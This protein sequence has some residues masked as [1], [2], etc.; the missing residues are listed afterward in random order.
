[1]LS[2]TWLRYLVLLLWSAT[3]LASDTSHQRALQ[4]LEQLQ[5]SAG[6]VRGF[7]EQQFNPMLKQPVE[8]SGRVWIDADQTM[9][10]ELVQPRPEQRRLQGDALALSRP[11]SKAGQAPDFSRIHHRL[12]L[13]PDK[14]AH[15]ILLAAGALLQGNTQWVQE[16]FSLSR[17]DSQTNLD[18]SASWEVLL[19]PRKD[20]LRSELS[21]IRLS[22]NG[23][24]LTGMR[25]DRGSRGWQQLNF[26][27]L[28]APD[29]GVSQ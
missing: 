8:S 21:W 13:S 14:A 27:T 17:G 2:A 9:V 19:V 5:F 11:R 16:H 4:V 3:A 24:D 18:A 6:T 26:A 29:S 12:T 15:L 20:E 28:P 7:S 1:M 25:A 10:M 22:G 23:S